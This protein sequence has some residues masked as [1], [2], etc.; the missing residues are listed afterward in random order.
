MS[1][2]QVQANGDAPTNAK[3][4]DYVVT[5]GGTYQ[6]LDSSKYNGLSKEELAG[7]GVSYNPSSGL[8]SKKVSG[9]TPNEYTPL[10]T[11][12]LNNWRTQTNQASLA[13]LDSAYQDNRRSLTRTYNNSMA[14]YNQQKADIKQNYL[15]NITQLYDDTYYNNAQAL[16]N[17]SSR[18]LTSSGLGNAMQVSALVDASNKNAY[19]RASRDNEM[20]KITSAINTLTNNYNV[21]L[22]ALDEKLSADKNAALSENEVAYLNALMQLEQYNSQT[23]NSLLSTKQEQEWQALENEKDRE[24]QRY[25]AAL[26]LENSSNYYGGSGRYG[27]SG[28][29][30]GY[31]GN[32]GYYSDS[33]STSDFA[34]WQ[35]TITSYMKDNEKNLTTDQEKKLI[36]AVNSGNTALMIAT[37]NDVNQEVYGTTRYDGTKLPSSTTRQSNSGSSHG[38]S[39]GTYENSLIGALSKSNLKSNN[40]NNATTSGRAQGTTYKAQAKSSK[41]KTVK[42]V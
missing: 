21:D 42:K 12:S 13:N 36:K 38:G 1:I 34:G 30:N 24:L 25:L 9:I 39:G 18:G 7:A 6:V 22:D 35:A 28:Y 4:G 19:Y 27:G 3:S 41:L 15:D 32:G 33:S 29:Y 16:E 17:A 2:Y 31:Y 37:L 20:N 11:D 40:S 8:Y 10:S 26:E 23:Y 14:D 5:A